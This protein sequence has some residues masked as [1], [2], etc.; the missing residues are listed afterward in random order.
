[1]EFADQPKPINW[2][3]IVGVM[4][5]IAVVVPAPIMMIY[6]SNG[7]GSITFRIHDDTTII[8]DGH[9]YVVHD[10]NATIHELVIIGTTNVSLMTNETI[11]LTTL[12][13]VA[14]VIPAQDYFGFILN[15]TTSWNVTVD[16]TTTFNGT[17]SG[18]IG[19]NLQAIGISFHLY[20]NRNMIIT[21][22]VGV[23]TS[24]DWIFGTGGNINVFGIMM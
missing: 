11:D 6:G 8:I 3:I 16:G 22:D 7:T 17:F 20:P 14:L 4:L 2:T 1:M 18:V 19:V 15:L 5:V 12:E 21:Y 13:S 23:P 24:T 9:E 10:F